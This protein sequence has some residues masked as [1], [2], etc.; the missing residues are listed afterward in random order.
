MI[1]VKNE[2]GFTLIEMLIVLFIVMCLTGIVTK[3][4]LKIAETKEL[5]RFFYTNSIGYSIYSNL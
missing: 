4:S 5:E 3:L 2:R 1:E